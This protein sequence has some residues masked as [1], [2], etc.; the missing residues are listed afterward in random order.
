MRYSRGTYFKD[1]VFGGLRHD[2]VSKIRVC[3][4]RVTIHGLVVQKAA[5]YNF[6]VLWVT[7]ESLIRDILPSSIEL[8]RA[9][10]IETS[11]N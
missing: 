10:L 5:L 3:G 6:I 1:C 9:T 8:P 4:L 2:T 7:T 11:A